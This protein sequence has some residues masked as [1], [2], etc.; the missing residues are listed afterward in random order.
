MCS[1]LNDHSRQ[2]FYIR[3]IRLCWVLPH[4]PELCKCI[5]KHGHN[6]TPPFN[7]TRRYIGARLNEKVRWMPFFDSRSRQPN[8][9]CLQEIDTNHAHNGKNITFTP[10]RGIF[11][12]EYDHCVSVHLELS[13]SKTESYDTYTIARAL[14]NVIKRDGDFNSTIYRTLLPVISTPELGVFEGSQPALIVELVH[15]CQLKENENCCKNNPD[16]ALAE[17]A[18]ISSIRSPVR[19]SENVKS[20]NGYPYI[21]DEKLPVGLMYEFEYEEGKA[22]PHGSFVRAWGKG[23]PQSGVVHHFPSDNKILKL[24][25]PD[26]A[27]DFQTLFRYMDYAFDRLGTITTGLTVLTVFEQYA[28]KTLE[29][30]WTE[31]PK[32]FSHRIK[33]LHELEKGIRS[34]FELLA[35]VGS[36]TAAGMN[37][38]AQN[39]SNTVHH[40]SDRLHMAWLQTL[41]DAVRVNDILGGALKN[42]D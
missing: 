19:I 22:T 20:S 33:T 15:K 36:Y 42:E 1:D 24:E 12:K 30:M 26:N 10:L 14:A 21:I 25:S 13:G 38:A 7:Y 31:G 27:S 6:S 3:R 18:A 23:G 16:I 40:L 17:M 28:R 11:A 8:K 5:D 34:Q 2:S 41:V 39:L 29:E 37:E 4:A 32:T 35:M 9:V